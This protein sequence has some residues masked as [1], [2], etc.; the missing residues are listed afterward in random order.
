MPTLDFMETIEIAGQKVVKWQIGASTFLAW[1][2]RGARLMHWNVTMADGSVRDVIYWPENADYSNPAAIR[3]GNPILFPFCGRSF[4]GSK[5]GYWKDS[6]GKVRPM[7]RH[8]FARDGE[9]DVFDIDDSGFSACLKPSEDNMRIFPYNYEFTVIYFF[10]E[11]TFGVEFRLTNL[12]KKPI[13]WSAGHHFY[14]FLPWHEKAGRG[15]YRILIPTKKAYYHTADGKLAPAG[16]FTG[17]ENFDSRPLVDRIHTRLKNNMIKF[18]PKS[19]EE[20]IILRIGDRPVPAT[21]TALITWTE[22][23]N[24]KFYC[25]EPW[26]GPPNA[27]GHKQGLH[28]VDPGTTGSFAVEVSLL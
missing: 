27:P 10:R 18:G 25:V 16:E 2:D 22:T 15:D 7:P 24:S 9:F 17:S 6:K 13:P 23:D 19:G 20:D 26:M 1:P 3:G 11:L 21:N 12:D 5:E 8:G 4:T 28:Y 14:F